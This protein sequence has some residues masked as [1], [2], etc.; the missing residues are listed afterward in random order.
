MANDATLRALEKR[1]RFSIQITNFHKLTTL[2]TWNAYRI[3]GR[4]TAKIIVVDGNYVVPL[5]PFVLVVR[6]E[7]LYMLVGRLNCHQP[8]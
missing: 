8:V 3:R 5:S 2:D 4:F 1:I 6:G 7:V